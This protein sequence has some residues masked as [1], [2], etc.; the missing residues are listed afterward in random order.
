[1]T[2]DQNKTALTHRVTAV[3]AAYLDGLGCKPV[4]TEVPVQIGWVA[5]VASYWYPTLTEAK[6]LH[7]PKK[8]RKLILDESMKDHDLVFRAYGPGP[9]TVLVEVKAQRN[10]FLADKRKW[11]G[12]PPAHICCLAFLR[13]VLEP[14]EIPDGWYG[15]E[16]SENGKKLCKVH[17]FGTVQPQHPGMVIDFIAAVGIRRDHRTRYRA[18]RD[19]VRAYNAKERKS[20]KRYS[21]ACMLNGLAAWLQGKGFGSEC[22]LKDLLPEFGIE[23]TPPWAADAVTYFEML[24]AKTGG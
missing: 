22:E 20:K 14:R 7:L 10:D 21:A 1:V 16:V 4:E 19:W 6:K 18:E 5:D 11:T 24:K 12:I 9:F 17:R 13:G 8:A 2:L 3:A 23:K 15:L